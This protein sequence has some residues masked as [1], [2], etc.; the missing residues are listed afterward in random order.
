M[1]KSAKN[2]FSAVGSLFSDSLLVDNKQINLSAKVIVETQNWIQSAVIAHDL[3]P[4]AASASASVHFAVSEAIDLQ[5][6]LVD[7]ALEID[8]L[9]GDV[10]TRTSFVIYPKGFGNFKEYLD[11][12]YAAEL[13]LQEEKL[14]GVYQI[15][16][17]HPCYVFQGQDADDTANFSNRAP[18]PMLHLLNEAQV[19]ALLRNFGDA[20]RIPQRNIVY[21]R[22]LGLHK[23]R[24]L[25]R[26]CYI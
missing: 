19:E 26:Q 2:R 3:C 16:S 24:D 15:A 7:L 12:A 25:L 23:T 5:S 9:L 1:K 13:Y 10:N 22:E 8:T 4:F 6:A 18:Y 21:L 14:Q 20:A 17:F 11:L